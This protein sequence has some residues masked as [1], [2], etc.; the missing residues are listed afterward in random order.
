MPTFFAANAAECTAE[1]TETLKRRSYGGRA[2]VTYQTGAVT[3]AFVRSP[4][5]PK[6]TQTFNIQLSSIQLSDGEPE[7]HY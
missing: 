4:G 5:A 2:N 1:A 6:Y 7:N 3:D